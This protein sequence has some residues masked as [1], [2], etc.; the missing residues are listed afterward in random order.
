MV[1]IFIQSVRVNDVFTAKHQFPLKAR[2]EIF[3]RELL[4]VEHV[5]RCSSCLRNVHEFLDHL[6]RT[7]SFSIGIK[8]VDDIICIIKGVP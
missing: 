1:Q 2:E 6:N 5:L 4:S 8:Q 3:R 7:V